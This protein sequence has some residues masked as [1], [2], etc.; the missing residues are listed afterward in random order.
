MNPAKEK[1]TAFLFPLALI[2][3]TVVHFF[4]LSAVPLSGDEAYHWEWSRHLALSYYDHPPMTAWL[5]ALSTWLFGTS[6]SSV[7]LPALFSMT[8]SFIFL[9]LLI[10]DMFEDKRL[11]ALAGALALVL[12]IYTIGSIIITTDPPLGLFYTIYIYSF[13]QAA[14]REKKSY[15][16]LSGAAFGAAMLCKFI[17]YLIIPAAFFFLVSSPN[18]RHWLKRKEPY[19]AFV[20][21]VIVFSPVVYWNMFHG[22]STFLFNFAAR[23]SE[24]RFGFGHLGEFFAGQMMTAS[25]VIFLLGIAAAAWAG[26]RGFFKKDENLLFLFMFSALSLGFFGFIGLFERVSLH[27]TALAYYTFLASIAALN[28]H[29]KRLKKA[30]NIITAIGIALALLMDA[31]IHLVALK[32]HILT[33]DYTYSKWKGGRISTNKLKDFYGWEE[34]GKRVKAEYETLKRFGPAFIATPTYTMSGLVAFYTPERPMV[35]WMGLGYEGV[36]GLNYKYWDDF[37]LLKG[38][39]AVFVASVLS[40]DRKARLYTAFE[41]V[42]EDSL[43]IYY[44]GEL[45][46]TFLIFRCYNFSGVNPA[47]IP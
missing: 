19:L 40:D 2:V 43:P 39:N 7:R 42:E 26:L 44:K 23:H 22:W 15:W 35:R 31:G 3:V 32:P 9:Y 1:I 10:R 36:N 21:G 16:Y 37:S 25:P 33:Y 8:V 45:K 17:A 4:Y 34:M 38:Q 41:R 18:R 30:V 13:Y 12:P 24:A 11:A 14:C 5:I 47:P 20:I 29:A 27:W 6:L 28:Y 46:R